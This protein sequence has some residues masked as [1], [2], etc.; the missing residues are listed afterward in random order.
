MVV[1]IPV[2][3]SRWCFD[4]RNISYHV[5]WISMGFL[6]PLLIWAYLDDKFFCLALRVEVLRLAMAETVHV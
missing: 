2:L 3:D 5:L 4:E 6:P 1:G